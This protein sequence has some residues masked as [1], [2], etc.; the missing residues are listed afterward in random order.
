MTFMTFMTGRHP[1]FNKRN[2][3][4]DFH[5]DWC[6]WGSVR[7]K[8]CPKWSI[9]KFLHILKPQRLEYLSDLEDWKNELEPRVTQFW[10]RA[11][12]HDT[13]MTHRQNRAKRAPLWYN[14]SSKSERSQQRLMTPLYSSSFSKSERRELRFATPLWSSSG[15]E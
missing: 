5:N 12:F 6:T 13:I 7:A 3:C 8:N 4:A 10:K 15:S 1:D 14:T 9:F 11:A 2:I